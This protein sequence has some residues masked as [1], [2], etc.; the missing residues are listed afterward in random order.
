MAKK[1]QFRLE[2][3]LGL[4]KQLEEVRVR[5]LAQ[6]KGQLLKIEEEIKENEKEES[7]FLEMYVDFEKNGEFNSDQVMAYCEYK[8]WL[9][10]REK[11]IRLREQEWNREVERRR[12]IAVAAS[13]ERKLLENLRERQIQVHAKEVMG[14]EQRFLDEVSSIAFVRRARALKAQDVVSTETR[15]VLG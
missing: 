7:L 2:Q 3:V 4:R 5:E 8:E 1:F 12:Q 11:V 10:R 15:S 14:E 9:L 6:A 13:R